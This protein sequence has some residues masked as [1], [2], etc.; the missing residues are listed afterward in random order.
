MEKK[1]SKGLFSALFAPK[2]NSG[3]CN[4]QFEE[5]TNEKDL[6]ENQTKDSLENKNAD[7]KDDP[8]NKEND[9]SC[10]CGCC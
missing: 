9:N 8:E 6:T 2:S 7:K 1:K 5:I 3:C 4:V 10:S